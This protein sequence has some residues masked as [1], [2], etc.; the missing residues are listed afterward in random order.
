MQEKSRTRRIFIRKY[1]GVFLIAFV[2]ILG[3]YLPKIRYVNYSIDTERM[4]RFPDYTLDWWLRLGRYGLVALSK[5]SIF[6]EGVHIRYINVLTYLLLFV[7]VFILSYV[8]DRN[9]KQSK[10]AQLLAISLYATTP[11]ILEQTNFVLQSAPVV[12]S[13]ITMFIGYGLLKL[14]AKKKR[15]SALVLGLLLTAFSFS[16]YVSLVMGFIALTIVDLCYHA[17]VESWSTKKYF[18]RVLYSAITCIVSYGGYLLGNIVCL[19]ITNLNSS[20]YLTESQLWG[21]VP[22]NQVFST[23]KDTLIANFQL[24]SPFAFWGAVTL[25]ILFLLFSIL[26]RENLIITLIT[27]VGIIGIGTYTVPLLGYFGTLR[28]YFPVYPI[29][30]YGL[31]MIIFNSQKYKSLQLISSV[32]LLVLIGMQAF[33]TFRFGMNE[34]KVYQQEVALVNEMKVKLREK[35]VSDYTKYKLAIIGERNFE[36]MIHG[37]ML[38]NTVFAWDLTSN[39]GASYRAGDFIYNQGLKFKRITPKDYRTVLSDGNV[40]TAFPDKNSIKIKEDIVIIR[41]N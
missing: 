35:K 38:G 21:N 8:F 34:E 37:D 30:L 22:T 39:V 2:M 27:A 6:G 29:L 31:V 9:A 10:I 40:M 7:S 1:W 14:F 33:N 12:F 19:K 36:E 17:R 13:S 15:Y 24:K 28:S 5:M 3:T 20:A 4:I 32:I 23:I 25:L 26:N 41:L 11:V 16:V 18:M